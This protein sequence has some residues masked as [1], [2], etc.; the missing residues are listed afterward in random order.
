M[1]VDLFDFELPQ[2]LVATRPVEPRDAARLLVIGDRFADRAFR[3]LPGLLR[4]GDAL[5]VNETRVIAARLSGRRLAARGTAHVEATLLR[6][7]PGG[8]RPG[9]ADGTTAWSALARP[10]R[11]L[12]PGDRLAFD[13]GLDAEVLAR[14]A[15]GEVVLRF[16]MPVAALLDA[17]DR[18]GAMPIPPYLGRAAD[19]RD[20]T[21]YQTVVARVPGAVAAPTAALH[22][23]EWLLAALSEAGVHVVPVTLHVGA[24]T[25]RP[26]TAED[27]GAHRMDA[28]WG[29]VSPEACARLAGVRANGGRIVAL[30]TTSLRLIESAADAD[31]TVRPFAGDTDLFI[32]PGYRF[33][34]VDRLVT[35]FHLPR[36]TL[37]MLVCAFA[38]IARMQAAYAH[39]IDAGYRFYSYGDACLLDRAEVAA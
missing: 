8:S 7:I 1:R 16:A 24:G 5:V 37:F 33:R 6:E 30:G 19:A 39:A 15:G 10:A 14:D 12:R 38:G 32:V 3:D 17:L 28:E 20:R 18:V 13:G 22:L 27:T 36:S 26:V 9:E 23:T 2:A 35:N 4:R 21:D 31:G 11:R 29:E 25:F 34:V